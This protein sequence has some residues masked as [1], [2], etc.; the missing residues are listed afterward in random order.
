MKITE[1]NFNEIQNT[2]KPVMIKFG[3][4][5]CGPCRTLAPTIEELEKEYEGK[6]LVGDVDVAEEENLAGNFGIRNVPTIL[7]FDKNGQ[8]VDKC[9]GLASKAVLEAKLNSLL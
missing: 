4:S 6:A 7:F 1:E 3:A 8:R 2:G 5:W 9:V